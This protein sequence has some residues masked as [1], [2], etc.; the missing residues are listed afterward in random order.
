ME[1]FA[2]RHSNET[3]SSVIEPVA[4]LT[5]P[6]SLA[7]IQQASCLGSSFVEHPTSSDSEFE[8]KCHAR[9]A[10]YAYEWASSNVECKC[11]LAARSNLHSNAAMRIM[12]ATPRIMAVHSASVCLSD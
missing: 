1:A 8:T 4:R 6:S 11:S 3:R 9:F 7:Q 12:S 10:M 5:P 2:W